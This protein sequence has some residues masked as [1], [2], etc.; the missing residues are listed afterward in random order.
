MVADLPNTASVV[1]L[2]L[3]IPS[4]LQLLLSQGHLLL[5]VVDLLLGPPTVLLEERAKQVNRA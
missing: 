3:L 2:L 5:H 1:L 4:R